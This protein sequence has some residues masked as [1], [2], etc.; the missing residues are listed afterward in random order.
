[1]W[2]HVFDPHAPYRPPAPF[3]TQYASQ[4]Y[5][6]EVAAVDAALAPLLDDVRGAKGPTLVVVTG[7]HGE[8]LGDHGEASHGLFAY[9]STLRVPL[10]VAELGSD[11]G[12]QSVQRLQNKSFFAD[13]AASVVSPAKLPSEVSSASARHVDI[14]PTILEAVGQ[15]VPTDLPGRSLLSPAERRS[16]GTTRPVY[17][18]AMSATLNRGWAPLA[19]VVVDREKY[20]DLPIAER[21]DL[22][23]DPGEQTNLAGRAPDRERALVDALRSYHAPPP[24]QRTNEDAQATARLRSLGYLSGNAPAKTR[25][26]DADDPKR[27]IDLDKMMHDAVEAFSARRPAEA[28]QIYRQVIERRPGMSLAY[29]HLAFIEW[30]RGNPGGA[31]DALRSALEHG[32]SDV[33]VV[34]Q[35][36]GYL[37][38]TNRVADAIH[39]LEPAAK[40]PSVD[41]PDLLNS[42]GIAYA[43]DGRGTDARATFERVLR[44]N[45]ESSIPLE[46]LGVLA[47][48]RGDL[49]EA[50]ADFD[51]AVRAAPNSSRA[52]AG[53]GTAALR[54][55]DRATAFAAWTRAVELDPTNFDALYNL[56]VNLAR[57]GQFAKARPYLEQF[58]KTAPEAF[59]APDRRDVAA[60]LA[61]AAK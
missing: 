37:T 58:L 16:D 61:R 7:D 21:Y 38:D 19:G 17:F 40:D 44:I 33:R 1:V 60:L 55:G 6:G 30:Q 3:N 23:A 9:E 32:V 12:T 15:A 56:G 25:Y 5:Y 45:P 4:P 2:L 42:L 24:G 52:Q 14:M 18:E 22:R 41:D 59:Y 27:L 57:D 36:G 11:R 28:V 34:T 49:K 50:R 13:L 54:A 8:A 47:L 31:I 10:I 20:V 35:L 46:N 48:E 39:I 51:R 26:T 53:V 43:R 29:R